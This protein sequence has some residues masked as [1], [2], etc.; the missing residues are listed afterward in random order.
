MVAQMLVIKGRGPEVPED[1]VP[2]DGMRER[3]SCM[4]FHGS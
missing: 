3:V 1:R 2:E 4:V